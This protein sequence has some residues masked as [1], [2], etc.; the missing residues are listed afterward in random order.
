[1]EKIYIY[2]TGSKALKFLPLLSLK[3]QIDGFLDSDVKRHGQFL[4][5]IKVYHISLMPTDHY[6]HIIIASSY[7]DEI[8]K[9]LFDNNL[10]AGIPIE[11]LPDVMQLSEEYVQLQTYYRRQSN[12]STP[13]V[14][15][16][17]KHLEHSRLITDRQ[18]LLELLPKGGIVAELGVANGDYTSQI[19]S[20]SQ[21]E[22]LHLVDIWQSERYN[23]TLFNNVCAKFDSE[24]A[25]RRVHIH[26]KLSLEAAEDFP[27]EYFDWIYIDTS[28]CYKGTK[29][30]LEYYASKIKHGGI[31]AGHDYTMGNWND[32]FLYGVMEAVHEFC[33]KYGWCIKYLT[34]D[35]SENQSFAIEKIN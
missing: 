29:A 18:Q 1:M 7:I 28:H 20:I 10:K 35:L 9:T 33:V 4:L 11:E 19:L 25:T 6:D 15:L 8:N 24:L 22:K 5:G 31:I 16:K 27:E 3:Y 17:K 2:G 21:P 26:R 30:E 32:Q 23:E 13:L 34:M 14:P 12:A